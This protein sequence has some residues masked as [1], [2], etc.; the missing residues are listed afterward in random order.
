MIYLA[1]PY[2]HPDEKVKAERMRRFYEID[3]MLTNH[4][5]FTISP[6]MKVETCKH[7]KVPDDWQYWKEY[8]CHLLDMCDKMIVLMFD[9]WQDSVGVRAEIEY[10]ETHSIEIEYVDV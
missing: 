6:L 1:A 3:A 10:A 5:L 9:G 8:S 7:G 4:G 2:S